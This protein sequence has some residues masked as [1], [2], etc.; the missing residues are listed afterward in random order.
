M[1]VES[2]NWLTRTRCAGVA[3]HF[4]INLLNIFGFR[5]Q[6]RGSS[7]QARI[8]GSPPPKCP[9]EQSQNT[10]QGIHANFTVRPMPNG[11]DPD[12]IRGF[13]TDENHL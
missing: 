3:A 4:E 12:H 2:V 13:S 9:G 10:D 7:G 1:A 6:H 11:L 5:L 8:A